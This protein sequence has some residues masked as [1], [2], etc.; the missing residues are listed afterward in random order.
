[1][2][3]FLLTT[4]A[5]LQLVIASAATAE[6][7]GAYSQVY[8]LL[9]FNSEGVLTEQGDSDLRGKINEITEIEVEEETESD[10]NEFD[11]NS[12]F[13]SELSL[14][15]KLA[16]VDTHVACLVSTPQ[17]T[18]PPLFILFEDYRL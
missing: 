15:S 7:A 8:H 14:V 17:L 5:V 13:T 12:V 3:R 9:E 11:G 18:L 10:Q 4:L 2:Y 6:V 16:G 1:M